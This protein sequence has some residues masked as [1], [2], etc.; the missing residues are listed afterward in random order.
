MDFCTDP[1]HCRHTIMA[2]CIVGAVMNTASCNL[3]RGVRVVTSIGILLLGIAGLGWGREISLTEAVNLALAN[4]PDIQQAELKLSLAQLQLE[5]G[6]AKASWPFLSLTLGAANPSLF[7]PQVNLEAGLSL[8]FGTTNR[9]AGKLALQPTTGSLMPTSWGLSFSLSLDLTNPMGG[10]AQLA[11]LAQVVED[12]RRSWEKTK[13]AVVVNIIKV[14]SELLSLNAKLEQA[15]AN[16]EKAERDLVQVTEAVAA[17]LAG[18]LDLLQARLSAIEARITLDEAR[19]NCGAQ[20]ARF[21]REYLGLEEDLGLVPLQLRVEDLPATVRALLLAVDLE[22]AAERTAEVLA[23]H[24][25]VEEA[26]EDLDRTRWAWLPT[27]SAETA[28]TNNGFQLGWTVHFNLFSPGRDKQVAIA[29]RGLA[30][31]R[32]VLQTA[33]QNA[34][35]QLS[36]LRASLNAA[37]QSLERLPLEEEKWVLQ[38]EVQRTKYQIGT[39]SE[40]DWLEFQRQKEAFALDANQRSVSLFLAYLNFRAAVGWSLEW[41][42]WLK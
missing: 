10:A 38:E 19:G 42:E 22:A 4:H 41:E 37:L 23:S 21:A 31:A 2:L 6:W 34:W 32:L 3:F 12:A 11:S 27:L 40:S 26:Q 13:A 7:S 33:R 1:L 15:Q 39:L 18:N 28:W 9:L 29:E 20:Q 14:Y 36:D 30:S 16:L 8:P 24:E 25:K 35:R 17:G 5:T